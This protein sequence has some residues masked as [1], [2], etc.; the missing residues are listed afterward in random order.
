VLA[1][2]GCGGALIRLAK[3][4]DWQEIDR[5]ARAMKKS[6][7]GKA[8]RAWA[9]ALVALDQPEEARALLL[10]DFRN[11]GQELSML[12]LVA[13]ERELGL[14]GVAAAHLTRLITVNL[15][16]VQ[17]AEDAPAL[18][19][20]LRE[21]ARVLA[22]LGEPLAADTDMRRVAL[23]C[24]SSIDERD[25]EFLATLQGPARDQA[26]GQRAL[27]Q[28]LAAKPEPRASI[29][30][31]LAEQLE[32]ARKHSARALIALAE[33]ER[34]EIDPDDVAALLAAEFAG[35]LGPG[36]VSARRLSA[37]IGDAE[38]DDVIEAIAGLPEGPRE[39]ALLRLAAVRPSARLDA[40]R[41][42]WSVTAM[43]S[44]AGMGAHE[45]AKAW[46]VAA[47]LGDLS[48]AEFAL[49]TNLRDMIPIADP[50]EPGAS[51][52]SVHWSRRVPVDRRSF[53]LLLTLARLLELRDQSVL[54]LELRRSVII[55]GYEVGLAQVGPIAA[56]E[57]Q[58]Q[59]AL[60]R[61]WQALA[62]AEVVPGPLVD[63]VLP[64]LASALALARAAKLDEAEQADRNVVWRALGDPWFEAWEPRLDA[65]I[66][67]LDLR[68]PALDDRC[69]EL[70]RWLAPEQAEQL[71]RVGLDP[72][73]SQAALTAAL[74]DLGTP[75]TG[76]ALARAIEADLGLSCSAPLIHLLFAGLHALTLET[77]DERLVHAPE[78]D[79]STQLQ[80]HAELALSHGAADRALLLTTS[81]AAVH[82][83]PR[84]VW[85][86]AAIAGRSFDAR[87][88]SLTALREIIMHSDGFAAA[89]AQREMLLIRLRDV[90]RDAVL[91]AGDVKAVES[92]RAQLRAYLDEAPRQRR[93][94]RLDDL[95]WA[96]AAEP[97]ADAQAW[98]LLIDLLVT[99]DVVARHG[100]AATALE[101]AAAQPDAKPENASHAP[102]PE[103]AT[104]SDTDAICEAALGERSTTTAMQWIGVAL[105]CRPRE[106]AEALAALVGLADDES[107]ATL[108][109]QILAGPIAVEIEAERP[110]VLRSVPALAR[111]GLGL[112]VAFAL[113]LD[114]VWLAE[115]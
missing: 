70:G 28:P 37:W 6:P 57:V 58:R 11:G 73:A 51:K 39:Y 64:A 93:W 16:A 32:L 15:D 8:A 81:A 71:A 109:A 27:E 114:P 35:A 14:R 55:A 12:A 95:L 49:N 86:R 60:G 85:T 112:R 74:S 62:I 7:R 105:A 68:R 67:G 20:L 24:P 106:R 48:G 2:A 29:E 100:E 40:E 18:C 107:R 31:R 75:A 72:E 44:L 33:A 102:T 1:T 46:R 108:R 101:R 10:R 38:V 56:E 22:E 115:P 83:D 25:R 98:A 43:R 21:R 34:I 61:P 59:L 96:L 89:A 77:L 87:E 47:S 80:L 76:A 99:D 94:S 23:A 69:P 42:A 113:P 78:L 103:L 84:A 53:D 19:D 50:S 54:A 88:Y 36:M 3:Q 111:Q 63:E 13:L 26:K 30:A 9:Q 91:R 82:V 17:D 5:R 92:V 79:A 97:R 45:A 104:T 90:D 65:A 52:P 4:E 66:G 110:G 41:Q